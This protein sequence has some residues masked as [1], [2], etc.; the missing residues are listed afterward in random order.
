MINQLQCFLFIKHFQ[1]IIFGTLN[2]TSFYHLWFIV[3]A[4]ES[5]FSVLTGSLTF[6]QMSLDDKSCSVHVCR[7]FCLFA[8]VSKK[9]SDII[10]LHC[11]K[12]LV[13]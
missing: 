10:I 2:Q 8:V 1:L 3:R 11:F 6:L 7:T 9:V 12:I 4:E 5:F 13:P